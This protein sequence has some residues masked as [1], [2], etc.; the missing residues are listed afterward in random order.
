MS[1]LI[2]TERES[3]L[4]AVL[5]SCAKT[6]VMP[7]SAAMGADLSAFDAIAVLCGT[8]ENGFM[9]DPRLRTKLDEY[10]ESGRKMFI[11]FCI[12]F[13]Y[14]YCDSPKPVLTKRLVAAGDIGDIAAGDIL[15]AHANSYMRPWCI[16]PGSEPLL[17]YHNYVTAHSHTSMTGEEIRKGEWAVWKYRNAVMCQTRVCDFNK[18]R[19]APRAAWLSLL[20]ELCV[21]LTGSHP[22][23]IP[24]PVVTHVGEIT[25]FDA[26]LGECV[27][28][29]IGWLRRFLIDGGLGGIREGISH[30]IYP[31]GSHGRASYSRTDCAGEAAGA[32]IFGGFAEEYDALS[33]YVYG[34]MQIKGGE[35][36]GMLRWSDSAWGVCYGDDN[37][38]AMVP[39]LAAALVLG[40][41]KYLP[42]A[43]KALDFLAD[44]T[45]KD[46]LRA[47]RT[48]N[49]VYLSGGSVRDEAKKDGGCPSAHYNA[50]YHAA[51]L[52]G[53]LNSGNRRYLDIARKGLETLM[54]L[55]PDTRREQSETEEICR[56]IFPLA[57]LCECTG[58][59]K[60]LDMLSRVT[61]D[62]ESHIHPFGGVAEWD[63]GYKANCS[64]VSGGECSLLADN[65]DPVADLLYSSNWLP[66]G[67][68]WAYR[69]TGDGRYARL[70]RGIAEFMIKSQIHS[71]D[72]DVDGGWARA[73]DM[74]RRE[75]FGLPHDAGWAA[76]CIE[77]GW[78]VAEIVT[79]LEIAGYIMK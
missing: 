74:D 24:E 19:L 59:K 41:K 49:I 8:S 42:N 70:W 53:Y 25:D 73:F 45:A 30:A 31:D 51:L 16:M 26:Q 79:G 34:P 57:V 10:F 11:E 22:A 66:I 29:G 63:T 21:W 23:Y 12:S 3:D 32:F 44:T 17:V 33:S 36:D 71:A 60:H 20:D 72:P 67:L 27:K 15:D 18:A 62:L 28:S 1:L 48:D 14:V 46:G 55:Y 56:L 76:C 47:A 43:L 78:T 52:L 37:A 61:S 75:I 5:A 38:R 40:E 13:N 2:I 39:A 77:S 7:Q 50:W 4:S 64:R 6:S 54:S 9:I 58:E 65:G 35:Y 68:A 69:A